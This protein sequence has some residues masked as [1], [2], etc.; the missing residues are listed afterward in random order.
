VQ[1]EKYGYII[2]GS[3]SEINMFQLEFDI[4]RSVGGSKAVNF[5]K[6]K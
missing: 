6:K 2:H 3:H 4:E 1:V 5:I